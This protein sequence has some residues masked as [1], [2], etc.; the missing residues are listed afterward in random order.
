MNLSLPERTQTYRGPITDT[1]RWDRFVPRDDDVF[2]CAPGKCGTTWTQAI[3]ALLIFGQPKLDVKPATISPWIDAKIF[4]LEPTLAMLEAQKHR[5][6]IK[7]HTPLDGIPY[8]PSCTYFAVYRDPRDVYFSLRNHLDNMIDES[9]LPR[10]EGDLAE[11]FR[12]WVN[13]PWEEGAAEQFS[14]GDILHHFATF[15]R[16]RDLPNLHL[17]HY[18]DMRRELTGAMRR[19]AAALGMR[20]EA[21]RFDELVAAASFDAMKKNAAT[22]A[23]GAGRGFWKDEA[24]FFHK[25][26]NEQWR[27]VLSDADLALYH[28]RVSESL[29]PEQARWLERG[30]Q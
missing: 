1:A 4:P 8:F 5:R 22:F 28:A 19:M 17:F 29:S 9:I 12:T 2:I 26:A 30:E 11:G 6:F 14:L 10:F 25:G 20:I 24:R 18:G 15:W 13:A 27:G 7:T 21:E 23:P 16:Y 3:C